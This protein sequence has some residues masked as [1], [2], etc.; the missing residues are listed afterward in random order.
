MK[1]NGNKIEWLAAERGCT[2]KELAE[3]AGITRQNLS[4]VKTRGTCRAG[5]IFKIAKALGVDVTE[6]L[7]D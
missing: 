6:L 1:I 3:K 5:T 4:T 2:L 7:E